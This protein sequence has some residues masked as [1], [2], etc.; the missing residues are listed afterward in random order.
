MA[1]AY[2]LFS[3]LTCVIILTFS[4]EK[5]Q[6]AQG[7]LTI[8]CG[9]LVSLFFFHALPGSTQ[10]KVTVLRLLLEQMK[11]GKKKLF[12]GSIFTSLLCLERFYTKQN[13]CACSAKK[14]N[15]TLVFHFA[16]FA[17]P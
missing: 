5:K 6:D 2:K 17:V 1:K 11:K 4:Q 13:N 14:N 12:L 8:S 7:P 9:P 15:T 16:L 10:N 3:F